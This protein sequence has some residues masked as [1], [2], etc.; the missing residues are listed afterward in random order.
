MSFMVIFDLDGT[1]VD[2]P[3]AIV[4][5]FVAAF[6]FLGT[7]SAPPEAEIR[8]TIG[9]PLE[10]SFA[11]LLGVPVDDALVVRGVAQ[12][13]KLYPEIVLPRARELVFPGVGDGLRRL[14]DHGFTLAIATSKR[15]TSAHALL[16]AAGLREHFDTVV[17]ADQVRRPKPDPEAALQ[18]ADRL[19]IAVRR[20]VVVGDTAYDLLMAKAAGM[21]SIGVTYGVHS[22]HE[23]DQAD[24]T[25][26]ADSFDEVVRA[27]HTAHRKSSFDSWEIWRYVN[28]DGLFY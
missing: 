13:Q 10:Q 11:K 7:A 18:I 2:T 16:V 5:N 27:I 26:T 28:Y 12:Y 9:L 6:D 22:R 24:P 19:G 23:L 8:A 1:L 17:G 15:Y 14:R 4:E 25:W 20:G 21:R 3:T